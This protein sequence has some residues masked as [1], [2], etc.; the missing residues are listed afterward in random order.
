LNSKSQE[1]ID[2]FGKREFD[3]FVGFIDL[4]GFSVQVQDWSPS[5]IEEHLK[6]FFRE[7]LGIL[8]SHGAMIDKTIGDEVMFCLPDRSSETGI[9]PWYEA[10][11]ILNSLDEFVVR[12]KGKYR[13]RVGLAF[14][15]L[16]I[17][18]LRGEGYSEYTAFGESVHLAKRLQ[19]LDEIEPILT[20]FGIGGAFGILRR[21]MSSTGLFDVIIEHLAGFTSRMT[22]Q[23]IS[24]AK[25]LKGIGPYRGTLLRPKSNTDT[26]SGLD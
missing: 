16:L 4:H 22:H 24:V 7:T 23:A 10:A 12:A 8:Y 18:Q 20:A 1:F 2:T 25:P 15:K 19:S 9:P 3:S 5:E 21:E 14:G 13:L 17:S 11:R 6:P 26:K